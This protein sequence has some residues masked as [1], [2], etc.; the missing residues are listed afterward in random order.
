VEFQILEGILDSC[1]YEAV[2]RGEIWRARG[3]KAG[4]QKN[5]KNPSELN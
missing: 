5:L 4:S 2:W 3:Q 1:L